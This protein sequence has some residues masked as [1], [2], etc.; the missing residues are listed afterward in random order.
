[1]LKCSVIQKNKAALGL[2]TVKR[3]KPKLLNSVPNY[4]NAL[5]ESTSKLST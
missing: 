4:N 2:T 1:M 5:I 3:P